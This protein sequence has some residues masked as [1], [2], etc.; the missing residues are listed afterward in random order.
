MAVS[1]HREM[2]QTSSVVDLS[3][4]L[5]S[6]NSAQ[7]TPL[8]E[9]SS[10]RFVAVLFDYRVQLRSRFFIEFVQEDEPVDP[11]GHVV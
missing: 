2:N 7:G 9:R 6:Q 10:N 5:F 1:P 3:T 11:I 4:K 8:V